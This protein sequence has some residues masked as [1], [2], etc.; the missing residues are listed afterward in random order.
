MAKK[1]VGTDINQFEITSLS[2]IRGQ[3]KVTDLLKVNLEAYFQSRQ[4][5]K[6]STFGPVLLCGLSGTG[7]SLVSRACHAE[8]AN[9]NLIETNGEMLSN[10]SE[11]VSILL[12]ATENTTIFIDE[13]QALSVKAQ[14]LLRKC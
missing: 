9:L 13:C 6:T 12:S 4:T 10:S 5:G 8:L 14:H 11:L 3:K 7:K 1:I 2:K